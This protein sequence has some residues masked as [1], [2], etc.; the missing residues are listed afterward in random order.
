MGQTPLPDN[1]AVAP[2]VPHDGNAYAALKLNTEEYVR[3][4]ADEDWSEDQKRE[5]I[6]ALWQIIVG[7]I[8]LKYPL[9]QVAKASRHLKTLDEDSPSMVTLDT[10]SDIEETQD[11]Q[12]QA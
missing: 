11:G 5:F 2:L 12:A 1:N 4:L 10:N 8:D 3:Y 6:E 7:V 9:L